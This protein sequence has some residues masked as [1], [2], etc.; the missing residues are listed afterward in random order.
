MGFEGNPPHQILKQKGLG[1]PPKST[2]DPYLSMQPGRSGKG[3]G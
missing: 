1:S 2:P 3:G